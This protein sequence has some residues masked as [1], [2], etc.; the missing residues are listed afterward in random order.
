DQVIRRCVHGQEAVDII[1]A[2]H[3]GPIGGHHGANL[4]AKKVFDSG[5]YWPTIYRDAHDLVIRIVPDLEASR[6][7]GFVHRP[8]ELQ[9]LAYGNL[10]S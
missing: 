1:T 9:S 7:C 2:C 4:T 10:I 3:N 6:A 5:F 8:L